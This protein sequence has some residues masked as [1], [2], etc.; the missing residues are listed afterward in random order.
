MTPAAT[1]L[2]LLLLLIAGFLTMQAVAFAQPAASSFEALTGRLRIGQLVWVTDPTERETRGRL[3]QLSS[4][5]LVLRANEVRTFAAADV[6]RLRARDHDSAKNGAVVGLGIGA[7]VGTAWC[8]GA[9][10]DDSGNVNARVECAEG[11]IVYPGLGVLLGLAVDRVIPGKLRVIYQNSLALDD[12][13]PRL[14]AVPILS[15]RATGLAV[16]FTF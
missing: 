5:G 11:F 10:A 13:R 15:T 6:R 12:I 8:I 3:E 4:D 1:P 16:A 7:A 9:V 14:S 2:R